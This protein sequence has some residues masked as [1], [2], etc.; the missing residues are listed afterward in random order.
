MLIH[1]RSTAQM[2]AAFDAAPPLPRPLKSKHDLKAITGKGLLLESLSVAPLN[3]KE[4]ATLVQNG[5]ENV[6]AYEN[7]DEL[8][9]I[10]K[11]LSIYLRKSAEFKLVHEEIAEGYE[12]K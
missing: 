4:E 11:R 2:A 9:R 5:L 10:T 3:A 7:D 8:T 12:S 1:Y 6:R